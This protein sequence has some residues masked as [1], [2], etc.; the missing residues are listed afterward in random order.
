MNEKLRGL[1]NVIEANSVRDFLCATPYPAG[2]QSSEI[3]RFF[4]KNREV[5]FDELYVP[6]LKEAAEF[7]DIDRRIKQRHNNLILVSGYKG[8]GKTTFIHKYVRHL[9]EKNIRYIFYNFDS[10]GNTDPIRYTIARYINNAI[11]R[12]IVDNNGV[13]CNKWVEIWNYRDNKLFFNNNIDLDKHFKQIVDAISY[14]QND[15]PT[16]AQRE[17]SLDEIKNIIYNK[18][19]LSDILI[20]TTF[21]DFSSRLVNNSGKK[22]IMVFDNLDVMY[23]SVQIEQ[24][25]KICSQFF[26]D[27]QYIFRN[28]GYNEQESDGIY[29]NPLRDYYMVFVMRETTNAM[30]IEHFNDRNLIGHPIDISY[31]YDKSEILKKRCEYVLSNKDNIHIDESTNQEFKLI[32]DLFKD[33]YIG[34]YLFKLFNDDIRTGINTITEITFAKN[35]LQDSID[36]RNNKAI[37]AKDAHF[38]S[39]GIIFFE[40]FKLFA[41]NNYFTTIKNT[42][43]FL[44][45]HKD[46][47]NGMD[48]EK[49]NKEILAINITRIIL[50]YLF[51]SKRDLDDNET[52]VPISRLYEDLSK[53]SHQ[54]S[55]NHKDILEIVNQSLLDLFNLRNCSYWN[56]LV[57]FDG[58]DCIPDDELSHQLDMFLN[59]KYSYRN[60]GAVRITTSGYMYLNTVLTH[61]EYF[62][63]RK[64]RKEHYKPLFLVENIE[65]CPSGLYI[66]E[67]IINIVWKEVEECWNKLMKFYIEIFVGKCKYDVNS[68][69]GSKFV[70]HNNRDEYIKRPLFHIERIVHAHISYLDAF[71]MYVFSVLDKRKEESD[72]IVQEKRD[73]NRKLINSI[74]RYISLVSEGEN[75]IASPSSL[76]LIANYNR[77]I[78]KICNNNAWDD[79]TTRIDNVTGQSI[80]EKEG[81]NGR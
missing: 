72:N 17:N 73:I 51:N 28:I 44:N 2:G 61:F 23:N 38:A 29:Y 18:M 6:S 60:Y 20:L 57:T 31:I 7:C 25:T 21:I 54:D 46:D 42:E 76:N 65:R 81:P 22:C 56:H 66:F 1:Y 10:Y 62:S 63:A 26:N 34:S 79:F 70:Y 71:R 32:N 49:G 48:N 5:F 16:V 39:H 35:T 11:Y 14:I 40:I 52:T 33:E 67:K 37:D 58:L 47:V 50:T 55:D 41:T 4:D 9:K 68:F 74:K 78:T 30:F 69:L 13:A 3:D 43:Y 64:K 80:A 8:C 75:V 53:L 77:C 27:A 24:F 15:R 59:Q 19:S 45:M 36:I 12:D